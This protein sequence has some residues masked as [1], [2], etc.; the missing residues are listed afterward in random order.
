MPQEQQSQ[1]TAK[2][3]EIPKRVRIQPTHSDDVQDYLPLL[4]KF[5]NFPQEQGRCD[6]LSQLGLRCWALQG[7]NRDRHVV[8]LTRTAQY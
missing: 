4:S 2:V 6:T 1:P 7:F 3:T 5:W 8:E